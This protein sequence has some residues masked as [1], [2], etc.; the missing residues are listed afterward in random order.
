MKYE[1]HI[2]K[3][4]EKQL[5]KVPIYIKE[6]LLLWASSVEMVGMREIRK[7]PAYHDEPLRG[8]RKGERSVRLS[9]A[10]RAIYR[11]LDNGDFIL[12]EIIEVNKHDY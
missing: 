8:K 6:T 9:R 11:E 3:K 4:A 2:T 5:S 10:Y 12:I 7:I 1:I